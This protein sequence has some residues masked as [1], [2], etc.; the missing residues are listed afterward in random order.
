MSTSTQLHPSQSQ[1]ASQAPAAGR[2]WTL[3]I[4]SLA[5]F[6]L[7]L[8]LTVVNVALPD[9]R[10]DFTASFTQLQWVLDA[11]ALGL[12]A[13]LVAAGSL[14][15]RIG[16]R[17]LFLIGLVVFTA[18][19]LF[20]G[21]AWNIEILIA[22]RLIQ[23][24]GGAILFAV[25]PALI[26]H[27]YTGADRTRAF[28]IFGGVGGLAIAFGPLLGGGLADGLDWRWIFLINVPVGL[29]CLVITWGRVVES[30]SETVP[31][32]DVSG[33]VTFS[34]SLTFFVLALLRGEAEGWTSGIILGFFA[35]SIVCAAIFVAIQLRKGDQAMFDPSLFRNRTYN[36]LNIIT[37]A[38]N[39]SVLSAIF[40][41]VTYIQAY[42]G[43]SAWETG[44]RVL[45]L[46][47][48]LFSGAAVATVIS[49]RTSPR[50]AL[51]LSMLCVTIGLLLIRMIEPGDDW[52]AAI[53]TM[54]VMGMGM[55]LF[56]PVRAELSVS[57]TTPERTGVASGV[58]ET[59]QQV[60]TAVGIAGLG[61]LFANRVRSGF[62]ADQ[63]TEVLGNARGETADA[64]ASGGGTVLADALPEAVRAPVMAAADSAFIDALHTAFTVAAVIAAIGLIAALTTIR[65]QDLVSTP[66]DAVED[67]DADTASNLSASA[68]VHGPDSLNVSD[69]SES[70][71]SA[72]LTTSSSPSA[73]AAAAS[74]GNE[75][76]RRQD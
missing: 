2:A 3:V 13:V 51:T 42:L 40:L 34:A 8:D 55:G 24:L 70:A 76:G 35:V 65:R 41:F 68:V 56:N 71:R 1:V 17:R 66:T 62:N 19:S 45:P 7:M 61:A 73:T 18:A 10:R 58:N 50:V 59:F 63:A 39:I 48:T 21:I 29:L 15:D 23:G 38:I 67:V 5:V 75:G 31:P 33:A 44:L 16:R 52:T 37:L 53:P 46:T 11:Y 47:L 14:A 30:R 60:G 27:V 20:C 64:A 4:A 12:A 32:L 74:F 36:G 22:A 28:G 26:G 57:T 25:G 54:I 72:Q 43:Y 6:M 49:A 69:D 9:I